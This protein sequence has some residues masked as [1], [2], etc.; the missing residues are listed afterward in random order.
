MLVS[1]ITQIKNNIKKLTFISFTN[2]SAS[3]SLST[4]VNDKDFSTSFKCM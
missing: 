1:R 2:P 3:N 4:D